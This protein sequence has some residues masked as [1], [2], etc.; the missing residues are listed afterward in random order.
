[1]AEEGRHW[2][3]V[4]DGDGDGGGGGA[5]CAARRWK[6]GRW[7]AGPIGSGS[8][9]R[10]QRTCGV[11][12]RRRTWR[13]RRRRRRP[14]SRRQRQSRSRM[15]AAAAVVV[16]A[17]RASRRPLSAPWQW[18][19]A[20]RCGSRLRCCRL[21]RP[22]WLCARQ[23]CLACLRR[24]CGRLRCAA[25]SARRRGLLRLASRARGPALRALC[26]GPTGICLA[27]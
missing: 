26:L 9:G 24:A 23:A 17:C 19:G 2:V 22:S 4:A 27:A 13:W 6:P 10:R 8:L 5:R 11:S 18:R 16:V 1:M 12:G 3:A 21:L 15:L 25:A 7:P 14:R 20:H